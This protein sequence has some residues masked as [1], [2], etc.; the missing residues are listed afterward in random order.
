MG[1][2]RVEHSLATEHQKQQ[3]RP[4]KA[5]SLLS[6][7]EIIAKKSMNQEVGLHQ[8]LN[9]LVSQSW[10]SQPL[11]LWKIKF[12]CLQ[13]TQAM[14][15]CYS[16]PKGLRHTFQVVTTKNGFKHCQ[17]YPGGKKKKITLVEKY[18]SR[19]HSIRDS[20]SKNHHWWEGG[21]WQ[22]K[23]SSVLY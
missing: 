2:Q 14:L 12:Y 8:T 15:F 18:R 9:L 20:S 4:K 1:L 3:K 7:F 21:G 5:P 10:N 11:E 16:S 6:P 13:M 19:M 17:I 22:G 23:G